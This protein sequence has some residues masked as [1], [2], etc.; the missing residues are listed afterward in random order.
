MIPTMTCTNG[1]WFSTKYSFP[2]ILVHLYVFSNVNQEL[3]FHFIAYHTLLQE[4]TSKDP[5]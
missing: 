3:H 4:I 1:E 2:L 5:E